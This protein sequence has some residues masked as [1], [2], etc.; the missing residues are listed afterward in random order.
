MRIRKGLNIDLNTINEK[1]IEDAVNKIVAQFKTMI[2]SRIGPNR[3][4]KKIIMIAE[5][6]DEKVETEEF[7]EVYP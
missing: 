3:P 6:I 7:E 4:L 1:E 5:I 2:I